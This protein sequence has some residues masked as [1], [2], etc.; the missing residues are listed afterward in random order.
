ME[1]EEHDLAS[2]QRV[3]KRFWP[4]R[5]IAPHNEQVIEALRESI[6]DGGRMIKIGYG[7]SSDRA[8][9]VSHSSR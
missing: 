2:R 1:T 3:L 7:R 8:T 4:H 9:I 6:L 5:P